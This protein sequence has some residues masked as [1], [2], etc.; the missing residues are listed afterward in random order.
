MNM[1]EI[2]EIKDEISQEIKN[3]TSE[4]FVAYFKKGREEFDKLMAEYKQKW[5]NAE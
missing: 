3:L 1:E 4:E 5:A 2:W